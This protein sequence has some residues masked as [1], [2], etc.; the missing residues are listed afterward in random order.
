MAIVVAVDGLDGVGKTTLLNALKERLYNSNRNV[1]IVPAIGSGPIGKTVRQFT[2]DGDRKPTQRELILGTAVCWAETNNII[3]EMRQ[4]PSYDV[5]LV[6]RWLTSF[7]VYNQA[8]AQGQDLELALNLGK[9]LRNTVRQPNM[10]F[11]LRLPP[12]KIIERL[13]QRGCHSHLDSIDLKTLQEREK[14]YEIAM[15][16]VPC[17]FKQEI[18][19]D[20]DPKLLAKQ[21]QRIIRTAHG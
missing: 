2:H 9:E 3:R 19:T 21:I 1:E 11:W 7:D 5:I 14:L 20:C 10:L 8:P 16:F 17:S 6:D 12:E 15:K 18:N 4:S 13:N